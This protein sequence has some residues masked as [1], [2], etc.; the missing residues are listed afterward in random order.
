MKVRLV[1]EYPTS[2]PSPPSRSDVAVRVV[3][4]SLD[5]IVVQD[6]LANPD[7][8][9]SKC[10]PTDTCPCNQSINALTT[11]VGNNDACSIIH[12]IMG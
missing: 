8:R 1:R 4:R 6:T 12:A 11:A 7:H 5:W 2:N 10:S 3:V 9:L